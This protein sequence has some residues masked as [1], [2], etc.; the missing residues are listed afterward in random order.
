[1]YGRCGD[2]RGG[3]RKIFEREALSPPILVMSAA[4]CVYALSQYD[5]EVNIPAAPLCARYF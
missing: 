4:R 3:V 1:M 5:M 2:F